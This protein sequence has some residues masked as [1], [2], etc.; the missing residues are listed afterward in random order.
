LVLPLKH[1]RIRANPH[2]LQQSAYFIQTGEFYR[3]D[4]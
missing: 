3:D 2:V 4:I 1:Y